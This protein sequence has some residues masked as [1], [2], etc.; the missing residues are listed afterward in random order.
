[1]KIF[2]GL[3]GDSERLRVRGWSHTEPHF[4]STDGDTAALGLRLPHSKHPITLTFKMA[5][6]TARRACRCSSWTCM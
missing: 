5:R 2:F 1:M 6:M 4:T 3:C